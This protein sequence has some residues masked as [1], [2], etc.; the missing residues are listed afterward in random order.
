MP[1]RYRVRLPPAALLTYSLTG[2]GH[3]TDA[4]D[5]GTATIAWQTDG[6]RY[7]LRTAGVPG[8]LTSAG[9]SGDAGIVPLEAVET[10]ARGVTASTRFDAEGQRI[11]FTGPGRSVPLNVG[12]Q[13][14]ASVLMQLAGMGLAEPDQMHDVIEIF[15]GGAA[16]AAVA[17]FQVQGQEP[18]ATGLGT[19]VSWH[20]VQLVRPGERRLELWLAPEHNWYPVQLRATDPDGSATT[21]VLQSIVPAPPLP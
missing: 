11:V 3:G 12:S 7:R 19:T 1:G 4:P 21:Q 18:V 14:R 16:D 6:D 17:R 9:A 2:T 5:A 8:T 10:D 20:L 13:D 15:V